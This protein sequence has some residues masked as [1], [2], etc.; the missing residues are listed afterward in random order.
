MT[1]LL[2]H[3]TEVQ[4]EF[5]DEDFTLK[6]NNLWYILFLVIPIM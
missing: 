3:V 6:N 2:L 5:D 1:T 4:F